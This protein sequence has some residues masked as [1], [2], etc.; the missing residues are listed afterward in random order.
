MS[1]SRPQVISM[2][3]CCQ[4]CSREPLRNLLRASLLTVAKSH[5]EESLWRHQNRPSSVRHASA[6]SAA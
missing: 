5:R 6:G 2:Q 1:S 4:G 3:T